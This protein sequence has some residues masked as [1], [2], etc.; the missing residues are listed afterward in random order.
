MTRPLEVRKNTQ[1]SRVLRRSS[2]TVRLDAVKPVALVL[3]ERA[4]E[5][6]ESRD[7]DQRALASGQKSREDLRAENG[8]F[9]FPG[10]RHLISKGRLF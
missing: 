2:K 9:A 7:A 1:V 5:K 8:A 6:N 3:A 4:R 10:A